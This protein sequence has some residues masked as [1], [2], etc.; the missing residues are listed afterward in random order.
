ME[1]Y[2][3]AAT[4]PAS[5]VAKRR[6]AA[7]KPSAVNG[8]KQAIT[9]LPASAPHHQARS[10]G[11]K[12]IANSACSSAPSGMLP[13]T[14]CGRKAMRP[15]WNHSFGTC[16]WYSRTSKSHGGSVAPNRISKRNGKP[17]HRP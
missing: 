7:S 8:A 11:M 5:G 14:L 9:T 1:M 12:T 10:P 13:Y 17:S 15:A 4:T 16:K 3:S 6:P 2:T